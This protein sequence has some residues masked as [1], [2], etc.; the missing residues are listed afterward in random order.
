VLAIAQLINV[1]GKHGF[2]LHKVIS[3]G[4]AHFKA[5]SDSPV[6]W[7]SRPVMYHAIFESHVLH[8]VSVL[9]TC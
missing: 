7:S 6:A 9:D 3:S 2:K 1:S 4:T 8:F 5:R